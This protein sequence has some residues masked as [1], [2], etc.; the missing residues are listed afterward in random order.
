MKS[1][2][3]HQYEKMQ[4]PSGKLYYKCMLPGCPHYLPTP[5]LAIGRESLCWGGCNKLVVITKEDIQKEVKKPMCETCRLERLERKE[6]L[7]SL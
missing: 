7:K 4:W 1:K 5:E 3:F 6:V 2:H